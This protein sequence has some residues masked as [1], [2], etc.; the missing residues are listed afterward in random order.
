MLRLHECCRFQSFNSSNTGV[1]FFFKL[2]IVSLSLSFPSPFTSVT[3]KRQEGRLRRARRSRTVDS[4][5]RGA[6]LTNQNNNSGDERRE[7]V[8]CSASRKK[9]NRDNSKRGQKKKGG[10]FLLIQ[11]EGGETDNKAQDIICVVWQQAAVLV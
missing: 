9:C 1:F 6:D 7:T 10:L 2:S 11:E 4:A 3:W 8:P 5:V